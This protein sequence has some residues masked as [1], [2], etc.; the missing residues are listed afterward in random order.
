MSKM[1]S[2][3]PFGH[4]QDKLWSKE[5][6]GVKLAIWLSTTKSWES[7]WPRC[8]QVNCDTLLERSWGELQICFR[9]HPNQR[10]ELGVMNSQSPGSLN[11]DNFEI[12][13]W[14]SQDKKP[15][16]CRSHGQTQRILYGGT[17]WLPPSIGHCE[18][19]ESML[20][21]AC[22]NTKG[23]P[24]CGL[25][26]LWLVLMQDRVVKYVVPLLIPELLTWPSHPL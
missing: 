19:S 24:E 6:L 3:E 14:E 26:N 12:P 1:A 21:V 16:G 7:I 4:L 20:P 9:P 10:S 13:P 18:S 8:V 25:T 5:G 11:Q 2:H 22:P 15:F 17:W 23:D